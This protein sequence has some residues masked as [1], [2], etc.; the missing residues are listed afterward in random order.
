MKTT[1]KTETVDLLSETALG[2]TLLNNL[3]KYLKPGDERWIA[4]RDARNAAPDNMLPIT[5][6]VAGVTVPLT[7]T[8]VELFKIR[9]DCFNARASS[10]ALEMVS[11]AGILPIQEALR[12]A[13]WQLRE[14]LENAGAKFNAHD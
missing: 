10:R 6:T 4:I 7:G 2:I 1:D 13:E 9:E 3:A 12:N 14:A 5:F 8:L 11:E